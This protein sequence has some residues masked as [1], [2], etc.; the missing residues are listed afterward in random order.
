MNTR[1]SVRLASSALVAFAAAPFISLGVASLLPS[2]SL[3]RGLRIEDVERASSANYVGL[4]AS[5]VWKKSREYTSN[6]LIVSSSAAA[7][8]TLVASPAGFVL[9]RMKG[10]VAIAL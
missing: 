1:W 10:R 3:D 7:L 5:Q 4:R 8:V 9:S 6:T 2:S